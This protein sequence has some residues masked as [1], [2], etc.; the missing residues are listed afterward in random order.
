MPIP[1]RMLEIGGR[2]GVA[3]GRHDRSAAEVRAVRL[4]PRLSIMNEGISESALRELLS[5]R[6]RNPKRD[7]LCPPGGFQAE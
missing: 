6:S 7:R 4:R 1:D 2:C 3:A 5:A